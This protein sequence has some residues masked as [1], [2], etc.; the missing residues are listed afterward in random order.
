M[1]QSYFATPQLRD[2]RASSS[3]RAVVSRRLWEKVA[4][5]VRCGADE[6]EKNLRRR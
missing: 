5:A 2:W 1:C 6:F 3:K 4:R